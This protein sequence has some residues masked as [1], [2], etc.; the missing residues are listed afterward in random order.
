MGLG[1]SQLLSL[2][3]PRLASPASQAGSPTFGRAKSI[4]YLYLSGGPSQY[5]TFDP[6]PEA[7][8]EIR[9]TFRPIA[10][11]VPGVDFCELLP[12]TALIA[13]RLA[14]VRSFATDDNNHESGGYPLRDKVQPP[15]LTATI[16]HLLGIGHEAL[17]PDRLDRPMR[18]TEGQPIRGL[19]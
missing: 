10:T 6:K 4:I 13:D 18:A 19:V 5:E 3:S 17:F 1:L 2:N 12:R 11:N 15:D 9:G 8:V 14:V 16:L 7:P